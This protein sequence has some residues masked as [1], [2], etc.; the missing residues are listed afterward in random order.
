M[1]T[2]SMKESKRKRIDEIIAEWKSEV[3]KIP[4]THSQSVGFDESI[5]KPYRDLEKKYL[6][7]IEAIKNEKE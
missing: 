6:P 4:E 7:K 3:E 2:L 5:N 1:G